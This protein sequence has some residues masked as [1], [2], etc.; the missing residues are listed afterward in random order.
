[1][2]GLWNSQNFYANVPRDT[3]L[4]LTGHKITGTSY[5]SSHNGICNPNWRVS[6]LYVVRYHIFLAATVG[7][8]AIGLMGAFHDVPG[9]RC[10]Q[11][12]QCLIAP[13]PGLLDMMSNCTFEAIHQWLHM[14]DP[15]LSS[16]NIAYNNFPYVA[17]W[18]GDKI[19]DNFEECDCGTLKDCSKV[20]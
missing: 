14:W 5:Y 11:R 20:S 18:C 12:Y 17:R 13:N 3:S 4:L 7:A 19:I 16:L 10:F 15:C 1:Q 6:Y 2:F 9:C 8:H